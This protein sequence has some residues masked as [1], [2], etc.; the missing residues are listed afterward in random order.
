[1]RYFHLSLSFLKQSIFYFQIISVLF[2]IWQYV[3]GQYKWRSYCFRTS[4]WSFRSKSSCDINSCFRKDWKKEGCSSIVCR[5]GHGYSNVCRNG[6]TVIKLLWRNIYFVGLTMG[7]RTK[8][9][10]ALCVGGGMGITMC[11]EMV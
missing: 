6:I 10:S 2:R 8:T 5:R 9:K 4:N 3:L 7:Y 11:V 1:M